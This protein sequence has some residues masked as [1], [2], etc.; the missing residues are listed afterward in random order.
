MAR[1]AKKAIKKAPAKKVVK[2]ATKKTTKKVVKRTYKRKPKDPIQV[3]EQLV[4]GS[5]HDEVLD[6]ASYLQTADMGSEAVPSVE[7]KEIEFL[8]IRGL[9]PSSKLT[10]GEYL[11]S[12]G[13]IWAGSLDAIENQIMT[14]VQAETLHLNHKNK[15]V[16]T[17]S[18]EEA[19]MSLAISGISLETQINLSFGRPQAYH[20]QFLEVEPGVNYVRIS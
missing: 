14:L 17:A 16:R 12:V 18:W 8:D 15:L 13:Y 3:E 7:L 1:P 2:K 19:S 5:T 20:P 11:T 6:A 4:A 10:I 9:S